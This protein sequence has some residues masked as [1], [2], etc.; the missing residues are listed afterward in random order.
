MMN[1]GDYAYMIDLIEYLSSRH[2]IRFMIS[3]R[4]YDLLVGWWEKG[5]PGRIVR[6]AIDRVVERRRLK[7]LSI[8]SFAP[9]RYEIRKQHGAWLERGVGGGSGIRTGTDPVRRFMQDYP[10][11][12]E[13]L[14]M[15]FEAAAQAY[16]RGEKVDLDGLKN[17]L[18][19]LFREDEELNLRVR[20]FMQ[21]LSAELRLAAVEKVYRGNFLWNRF[22]IPDFSPPGEDVE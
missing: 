7:R 9:F 5:I 1:G 21:N 18:V 12:L 19:K 8:D 6:E 22:H 2:G 13:P 20:I 3:S 4:D 15:R 16:D 17:D 10:A 11:Q 14:R